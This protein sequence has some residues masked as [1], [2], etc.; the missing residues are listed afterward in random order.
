[1]NNIGLYFGTFNPIHI[2]HL[3][4]ANHLVEHTDLDAVWMVVTPR[5]PFKKKATLLDNYERYDL[6]YKATAPYP[7]LQPTDIEFGLPQPSYTINTLAYLQEKHPEK[8]FSLI[9]GEDNLQ[10]LHKWKNHEEILK[11]HSIYVY[12][13]VSNNSKKVQVTSENI[14]HIAAPI[15][16]ISSTHIRKAIKAGKNVRPLLPEVVWKYISEM[17]FYTK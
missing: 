6:V 16:E 5:S 1:M 13:R 7:L 17:N 2:G 15:V 3:I 14:H 11:N 9:M 4:I 12:P 8:K 10:G